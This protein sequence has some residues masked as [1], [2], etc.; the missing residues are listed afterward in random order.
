MGLEHTNVH[1]AFWLT[2]GI[3][4]IMRITE[5]VYNLCEYTVKYRQYSPHAKQVK[6]VGRAYNW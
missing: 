3:Y 6:I 4:T 5:E 1:K 2:F